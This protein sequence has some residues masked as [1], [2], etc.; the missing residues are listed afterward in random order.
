MT[1]FLLMHNGINYVVAAAILYILRLAD[2]PVLCQILNGMTII[3]VSM[4]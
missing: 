4:L 2:R 1:F 3:V